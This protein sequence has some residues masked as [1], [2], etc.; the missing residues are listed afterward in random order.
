MYVLCNICMGHLGLRYLYCYSSMCTHYTPCSVGVI[1]AFFSNE[2]SYRSLDDFQ[3]SLHTVTGTGADFVSHTITVSSYALHK[4]VTQ[5]M[6]VPIA[7]PLWLMR[8]LHPQCTVV[9]HYHLVYSWWLHVGVHTI[10][11][12]VYVGSWRVVVSARRSEW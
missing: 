10:L 2:Q 1:L 4:I 11:L 3:A 8:K 9:K 12:C 5:A 7:L 6:K